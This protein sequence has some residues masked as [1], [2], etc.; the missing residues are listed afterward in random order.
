MKLL[1]ILG[2]F[3]ALTNTSFGQWPPALKPHAE[4][5]GNARKAILASADAMLKPPQDRYL[6]ALQAA[7]RVATSAAKTG[8]L[9]AIAAEIAGTHGGAL[10]AEFPPDL[11]R[12]L[13]SERRNFLTAV[14]NIERTIPVKLRDLA[15]RYLQTL[16][17]LEAQA[18]KVK[19]AAL[20]QAIAEERQR[21]IPHMEAAGGGQKNRNVVANG[22]FAAGEA[23]Q[24]PQ[25]WRACNSWKKAS[26]VTM[27]QEG[28][29]RFVRFRRLQVDHQANLSP[30]K[31]IAIPARARSVEFSARIR[32][33]GFTAGKDYDIYPGIRVSTRDAAG[34][35]I[36]DETVEVK[37]D[38]GWKKLTGRCPISD[39]A[40]TL[41]VEFGPFSSAGVIDFDDV[42]VEFK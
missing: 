2:I 4:Q 29:D 41:R 9:A 16:A 15:T 19:D 23:G 26:D 1:V 12:S 6:A 31:E 42:I 35:K 7:E 38:G 18:A 27:M 14:A 10:P 33:K 30:E 36:A 25:S 28:N 3:I 34:E 37:Q 24:W 39:K 20:S 21:V 5:Y 8:D 11:P 40:K 22:D 17:L 32:V 13:A